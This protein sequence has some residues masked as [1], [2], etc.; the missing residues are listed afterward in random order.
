MTT[1][2]TTEPN[3]AASAASAADKTTDTTATATVTDTTKTGRTEDNSNSAGGDKNSSQNQASNTGPAKTK[4][5]DLPDEFW[6]KEKGETRLEALIKS[7]R[8]LRAQLSKGVKEPAPETPDKY[9]LKFNEAVAQILP[10]D[11]PALPAVRAAAH[12]A[13]ISNAQLNALIN[14]A[15]PGMLEAAQKSRGQNLTPEQREAAQA[16]ANKAELAKL[17]SDPVEAN[18]ILN[19]VVGFFKG[20]V[21]Q[22]SLTV[23]DYSALMRMGGDAA[24]ITALRKLI[25]VVYN[26]S[27][28]P[29]GNN[30]TVDGY[31]VDQYYADVKTERYQNDAA[32]RQECKEKL[33]KITG[34]AVGGQAPVGVGHPAGTRFTTPAE[35]AA[36]NKKRA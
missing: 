18:K 35:S 3:L 19:G 5:T 2:T 9:D 15:F 28:I 13:G 27:E 7:Q 20:K 32:F 22:G 26:P 6:D 29:G 24:G 10:A 31:S 21:D 4:P 12:K 14:E 16:E 34:N 25:S 8:D 36:A 23:D 17:H 11:D 33:A 30:Q 1:A